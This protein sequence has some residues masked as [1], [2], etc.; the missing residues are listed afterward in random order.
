[1]KEYEGIHDRNEWFVAHVKPRCEKKLVEYGNIYGFKTTL[2][3]YKSFKKYAGKDVVFNK[4]LFPGYVFLLINN[5]SRKVA[6]NS[7][8]VANMLYV[9]EQQLFN[10]QLKDILYALD[11]EVDLR[12]EPIIEIG[13]RVIIKSG[14]LKG[15]EGWVEERFGMETVLLRLDFIGQAAAFEVSSGALELI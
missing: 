2:P 15:Q 9:V 3:T 13:N 1:M 4:P 11:Q 14:P 12:L 6:L 8:F 10:E 5:E 7:N